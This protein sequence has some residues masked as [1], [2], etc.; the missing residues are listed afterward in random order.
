MSITN[1]IDIVGSIALVMGAA[2]VIISRTTKETIS[3]QT[4]L[5]AAQKERLDLLEQQHIENARKI[6]EMQGQLQAYKELPLKQIAESLNA[7]AINQE[8]IIKLLK[9]GVNV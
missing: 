5:I 8:S 9:R 6:G 2:L 7:L 1:T 3:Q 4:I